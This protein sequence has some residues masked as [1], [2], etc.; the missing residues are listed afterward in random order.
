VR[1]LKEEDMGRARKDSFRSQVIARD[2]KC[3]R[4]LW[5][6]YLVAHHIVAFADGGADH[7]D[8]GATLC[9]ECHD[10]WHKKYEFKMPFASFVQRLPDHMW[11]RMSEIGNITRLQAQ[12]AFERYK[13]EV[14]E[15]RI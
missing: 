6:R 4:C 5:P 3:V 12:K 10:E 14:P 2:K 7:P 13:I 1:Y 11:L 8:N 9:E 15:I